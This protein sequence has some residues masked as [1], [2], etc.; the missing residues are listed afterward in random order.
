MKN[1][2]QSRIAFF[3]RILAQS[4]ILVG[5]HPENFAE[6]S[7]VRRLMTCPAKTYQVEV[8]KTAWVIRLRPVWPA[9]LT[10]SGLK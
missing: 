10:L 2:E 5:L 3:V 1:F 4:L 9:F 7:R 6:M 8:E